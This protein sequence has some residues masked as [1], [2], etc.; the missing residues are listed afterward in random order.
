MSGDLTE[1][2]YK[3]LRANASWT[4]DIKAAIA[5]ILTITK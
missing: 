4:G 5:S 2:A 3:T 1:L